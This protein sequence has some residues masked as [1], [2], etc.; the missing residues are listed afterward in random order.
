MTRSELAAVWEDFADS[1]GTGYSPLYARLC[2]SV[3]Q[4]DDLLALV[5][6]APPHS[7]FPLMLLA[8]V[9]YLVLGG[10]DHPLAAVYAGSSDADP[11]PLFADL[12]LGH[13]DEVLELLSTRHVNTNE[14][15]RS[16]LLVPALATIAARTDGPLA[17]VDV[18]CSAG[19]NLRCDAYRI[20]YGDAGATGPPDAPV[21]VSCEVVGDRVPVPA[22]VPE[23]AAR[24]GLD[25]DPVTLDDDG[26]RWLLACVWPD[27]GRLARTRI[28]L[29]ELRRDPPRVVGG[30]AVDAIAGVV[31]D[32]PHDAAVVLTT[33]WSIAYLSR[34]RR[35][36]FREAVSEI[37]GAR[38]LW[39]VSA[40]GRGVVDLFAD[41]DPGVGQDG[42][43]ANV[44]GLITFRAGDAVPEVLGFVHPH[45]AWIDW[46]AA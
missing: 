11:G 23:I 20:D 44:L 33:T 2:R 43:D 45:G 25:L 32:L 10:V 13:R 5:E 42:M 31:A 35:V 34:Q 14:V 30:D 17:F 24:V 36:A 12:C 39:W 4:N 18:G 26:I 8:A 37:S 22:R 16:A 7:H 1:A 28:A 41:V 6:E 27:T 21:Q 9:H 46:R 38:P 40:E 29:D 3:A 15:G 19:L